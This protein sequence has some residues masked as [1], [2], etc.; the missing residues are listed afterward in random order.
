[1][2]WREAKVADIPARIFRISFTGDLSFE[3]NV[4][5]HYG[6]A[7]WKAL[8]EAGKAFNLTPYG[9]E[10]MHVLRAEKGF[11]IVGQDTDGSMTPYDMDHGWAVSN[12]KPFSFIGKRGMNRAD[13]LRSDRKQLVGLMTTDP[14][15]KLPEGAQAVRDPKQSIPM[16]MVGHVTSSYHSAFLGRRIALAV[17]K[18]GL[19]RKGEKVY[20]PMQDGSF[21]EAEICSTV[22]LDAEGSRQKT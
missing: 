14:Q 9:T 3:I 22:F 5:A 1:M 17:I 19:Q 11:I 8:F 6:L 2:D 16:T 12:N 20:F 7:V 21:V 10:T 15:A 4:P 18:D 13:C